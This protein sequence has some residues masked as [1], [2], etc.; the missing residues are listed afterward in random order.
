L[1][2][3][4]FALFVSVPL[5][6]GYGLGRSPEFWEAVEEWVRKESYTPD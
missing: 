5:F 1:Q 3:F 2:R 4:R 6:V